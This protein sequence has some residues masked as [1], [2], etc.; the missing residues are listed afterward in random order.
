VQNGDDTLTATSPAGYEYT[1]RP[2]GRMNPAPKQLITAVTTV[3]TVAAVT[4]AAAAVTTPEEELD[5]C[6][7]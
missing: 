4:T 3:T 6:P 1:V 2:E 5:D 7:F